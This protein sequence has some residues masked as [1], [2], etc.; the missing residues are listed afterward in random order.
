VPL[1]G[2]SDWSAMRR[3]DHGRRDLGDFQTPR[4]LV[5]AVLRTLGP[6][7]SRWSRILEPTCGTGSFLQ[8]LIEWPAPPRELIGIEVQES[9]WT[10]ARSLVGATSGSRVKILRASIFDLDLR[11]GLPWHD[12]GPL[13]VVGNPPW[14]TAA[15]LGKLDSRNV[16]SKRNLKELPGIQAR[17]GS[18]NFD[19][20]EAIWIKLLEELAGEQPTIALLCKTSAA[21]AVLEFA[22]RQ[23]MPIAEASIHEIDAARWF[24][25]AVGACL[26]RVTMGR[27]D[28]CRHPRVPVFAALDAD[29]PNSALGFHQ[30]RLIADAEAVARHA[31]AL[32]PCPL[33]WRQGIKHD[34]AAVVEL[35]GD[36]RSL[37]YRNRLGQEVEVEPEFVYPLL[38]GNDLRKPAADRPRRALIV[39]QQRIGQPTSALEQTAPEL[40]NYLQGHA[41]R[42]FARKSSIYRGQPAF[43]MF[44][45]G[46]YSFA[47]F[48]VAVS[49]MCR[50][51]L[52]RAVGPVDGRPVM[53]DDTCYLLP[54][55]SAVEAAV[56]TALYHQPAALELIRALS[57]ADAKRPVTK[58]LLQ[59]I[60]LSAI[61]NQADRRELTART[62]NVLVEDL[63]MSLDEVP[64]IAAEIE[65][66]ERHFQESG[67]PRRDP[68]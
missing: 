55:E 48:K 51:P 66:L 43:A 38:K 2:G 67:T 39:T 59:R 6:I 35:A 28:D 23:G 50:P 3:S 25:A 63:G 17:T 60:D 58:G 52:F 42:F 40:W 12:R 64:G 44:G 7:G 9:H 37:P 24:G 15:A 45:V 34:A 19:I 47:P 36:R 1:G 22:H 18:S 33:T 8:A 10:T 65:R 11:T 62:L 61:L 5:D 26:L 30:G 46:P 54:C 29:Q 41:A 57:F 13:L 21:R 31:F 68:R 49:G 53:L 20:A 4:D 56:L 32:G 14:I 16:P 27:A